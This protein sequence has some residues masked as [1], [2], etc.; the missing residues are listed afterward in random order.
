MVPTTLYLGRSLLAL[1]ELN[2][3]GLEQL[4]WLAGGFNTVQDADF[5]KVEGPTKLRFAAVGGASQYVLAFAQFLGGLSK[6][7]ESLD[8]P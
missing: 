1:E 7:K 8:S 2:D 3:A 6:G 4:A 5:P